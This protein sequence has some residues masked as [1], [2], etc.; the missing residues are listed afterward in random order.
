MWWTYTQAIDASPFIVGLC[1]C[2]QCIKEQQDSRINLVTP[3]Q[4][5]SF[6]SDIKME[7][8]LLNKQ[9]WL[10]K[11]VT[12][13]HRRHVGLVC[14]WLCVVLCWMILFCVLSTLYGTATGIV[15]IDRLVLYSMYIDIQ[16][17]A[18]VYSIHAV[19]LS[20]TWIPAMKV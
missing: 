2:T 19:V 17:L 16:S 1:L 9:K 10:S 20:K 18:C 11:R 14:V 12:E 8:S 3:R 7:G 4:T 6:Q 5:T 15:C 13:N